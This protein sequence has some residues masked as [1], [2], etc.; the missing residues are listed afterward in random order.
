MEGETFM[1]EGLAARDDFESVPNGAA[2][3]NLLG[4]LCRKANRRN[5]AIK[6]FEL[7]LKVVLVFML[8][9][10]KRCNRLCSPLYIFL[11]TYKS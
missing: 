4:N 8:R 6:Y 7:S 5:Q 1:L 3:L 11:D 9:F 10:F 2:G